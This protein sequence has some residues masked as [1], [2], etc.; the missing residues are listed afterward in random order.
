M[1]IA[2]R[3]IRLKAP[4]GEAIIP[5]KIH[6]PVPR[7]R[8]WSCSF[9]IGWPEGVD[10]SHAMGA[11]AVQALKL[12]MEKIAVQLYASRYHKAGALTWAEGGGYGFPLPSAARELAIGDDKSG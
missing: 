9:E 4:N 5:V 8:A 1:I 10:T 11:D 12:A 2:E 6:Q 3:S 7:K